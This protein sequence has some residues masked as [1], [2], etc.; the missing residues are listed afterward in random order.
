MY[1]K[2]TF[3]DD[4]SFST[5]PE[6]AKTHWPMPLYRTQALKYRSGE[7]FEMQVETPDLSEHHYWSWRIG[8]PRS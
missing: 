5:G 8:T 1:F 7:I 6:S 3:D 4:I 2:A